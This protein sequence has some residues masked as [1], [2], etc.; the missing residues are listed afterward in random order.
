MDWCQDRTGRV[1]AYQAA[2]VS[3]TMV[4]GWP[5]L[6]W[7]TESAWETAL[8]WATGSA[9]PA[10]QRWATESAWQS[11]HSW[12]TPQRCGASAQ[13]AA[14]S[15]PPTRARGQAPG[16]FG[17][18]EPTAC[19]PLQSTVW[20]NAYLSYWYTS[21]P[22]HRIH[23][24][25]SAGCQEVASWARGRTSWRREHCQSRLRRRRRLYRE[26]HA[27]CLRYRRQAG[28]AAGYLMR[29]TALR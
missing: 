11:G 8:R 7:A 6:Q 20:Y 3:T 29:W 12:A 25:W 13:P 18:P 16:L 21:K 15:R 26:R 14:S 2:P 22:P 17:G 24:R 4:W 27:A 1:G 10:V 9:S 19:R 23:R 28:V 5:A